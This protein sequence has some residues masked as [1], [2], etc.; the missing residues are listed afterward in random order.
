MANE[1]CGETSSK[2]VYFFGKSL[3]IPIPSNTP[4]IVWCSLVPEISHFG[5]TGKKLNSKYGMWNQLNYYT[6]LR[7]YDSICKAQGATPKI[8]T[9]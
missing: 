9:S 6:I 1:K 5:A 7:A 4:N 8:V 2:Q 3:I